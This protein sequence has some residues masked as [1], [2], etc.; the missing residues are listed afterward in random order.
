[1]ARCRT[2]SL[3]QCIS[4]KTTFRAINNNEDYLRMIILYMLNHY[5]LLVIVYLYISIV[6]FESVY[7]Y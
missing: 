7:Y 4:S 1:M 6:M 5:L 2:V 3:L